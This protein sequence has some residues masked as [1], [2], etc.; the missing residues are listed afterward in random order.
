M[1]GDEH[2]DE[3]NDDDVIVT[4]ERDLQGPDFE[5]FPSSVLNPEMQLLHE[6]SGH[7]PKLSTCPVCQFSDGPVFQHRSL[8]KSEVGML[9]VDLA[10][11]LISD[12]SGN[13]Y[14]VVGVWVGFFNH[15]SGRCHHKIPRLH[16]L[17]IL[18]LHTD[19]AR[20]FLGKVAQNWAKEKG[21]MTTQ[22]G[23]HSPASN[24]RAECCIRVVKSIVRRSLV[25]SELLRAYNLRK[26]GDKQVEQPLPFGTLVAVRRPGSA[27]SFKPFEPRGNLGR[28]ILH[29]T[30]TRRCFILDQ[31]GQIWK[32][33]AAK[34]I[35]EVED[36]Y[37]DFVP[38]EYSSVGWT[39][40]KL[41][42]GR[43]A[44][45]NTHDGIFRLTRPV[46]IDSDALERV[47]DEER[48][49][50]EDVVSDAN[51][52]VCDLG[53]SVRCSP[54][55][56]MTCELHHGMKVP[57][58]G[59][60]CVIDKTDPGSPSNCSS[61]NSNNGNNTNYRVNDAS[62]DEEGY[63]CGCG[64]LV[65]QRCTHVIDYCPHYTCF[66][67]RTSYVFEGA[68]VWACLHHP[69]LAVNEEC[70]SP[71]KLVQGPQV[72]FADPVVT[73]VVEYEVESITI[74]TSENSRLSKCRHRRVQLE[75]VPF[76]GSSAVDA[77]TLALGARTAAMETSKTLARK[78]KEQ[79][80]LDR[81]PEVSDLAKGK[82]TTVTVQAIRAATG[83]ERDLWK[84]ALQAELSSLE[85]HRVFYKLPRGDG[86]GSVARAKEAGATVVPARVVLVL[87]PD[88]GQPDGYKRKARIVACGNFAQEY[89]HFEVSNLEASVFRAVLSVS[90]KKNLRIG[91]LDIKTAFL[92]A[93]IQAGRTVLVVPPKILVEYGVCDPGETWALARALYG[94]R[95]SPGLWADHR[96][97]TIVSAQVDLPG[98]GRCGWLQSLVHASVWCLVPVDVLKK[99]LEQRK[100]RHVDV[101]GMVAM[102]CDDV[103][104]L[105]DFSVPNTWYAMMT[106]YVD[107]LM[108]S[109]SDEYH[110]AVMSSLQA[111]WETS[112]PQI[113]GVNADSLTYLGVV[114]ELGLEGKGFVIHQGPYIADLLD[115]YS[116]L[117]PLRTKSTTA[118]SDETASSG[119]VSDELVA[120]LRGVLGAILWV[121]TRSRPDLAWS[122]SMASGALTVDAWDC[123]QRVVHMLGY[124]QSQP[125]LG[126]RIMPEGDDLEVYT[127]ISFAPGGSR[128]HS[129]TVAKFG[130]SL[131]TWRSHKQSLTALST[132][133]AELYSA[134]E[135]LIPLRAARLVLREMGETIRVA[136]LFCDNSAAVSIANSSSPPMRSRH[137]SMRAWALG[138]AVASGEI[139]VQYIQTQL[140]EADS[141]T[142]LLSAATLGVH[143]K[144]LRLVGLDR[145]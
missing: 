92:H 101:A 4:K 67:C 73:Q 9:A 140:Q 114:V 41:L 8:R 127:D 74:S 70:C 132:A 48:V 118:P 128:S 42:N 104:S 63:C 87:K 117:V 84:R 138:E 109:A 64:T 13:R 58:A 31:E 76:A 17:R 82:P 46:L 20:E 94:L 52:V 106:V 12:S 80:A 35:L 83:G 103:P 105:E 45:L 34:P 28:L 11:P 19:R 111:L 90:A 95:E 30:G 24:G 47:V 14:I 38:E 123:K 27:R 113:L 39:K 91:I 51:M 108:V 99:V 1:F 116:D 62:E 5:S 93:S 125:E 10:G 15:R 26:A 96:D 86:D 107:D 69:E 131:L 81:L 50:I 134:V 135:G 3:H 72:S 121:V 136:R 53:Q 120:K 60:A 44:W 139:V 126:I 98:I 100:G 61:M 143:N 59:Q 97:Q 115:K 141:M 49:A 142:K 119:N 68:R 65:W 55:T 79:Q 6:E 78:K 145:S 75:N 130:G 85:E 25:S 23:A 22:I 112:P 54:D 32:G 7:Y 89:E 33:F 37:D 88:Q 40:V 36:C 57:D 124:L 137:W 66:G 18:R 77:A 21:V 133:E 29:E 71:C 16:G 102:A 144:L 2:D 129:G 110:S 43:H 122:H 56:S